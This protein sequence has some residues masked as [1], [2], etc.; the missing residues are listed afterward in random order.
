MPP[1][2]S[3]TSP[4][5]LFR[6]FVPPRPA[7]GAGASE[8][9]DNAEHSQDIVVVPGAGRVVVAENAAVVEAEAAGAPEEARGPT[10]WMPQRD[11]ATTKVAT[12]DAARRRPAPR[13]YQEPDGRG[14]VMH[15]HDKVV[16]GRIEGRNCTL[17][18]PNFAAGKYQTVTRT[19]LA[20]TKLLVATR[21][22]R[23]V[24]LLHICQYAN[25]PNI[26]KAFPF[27][28][29]TLPGMSW[30]QLVLRTEGIVLARCEAQRD[31]GPGT[32]FHCISYDAWRGILFLGGD[33]AT[34]LDGGRRSKG[35]R[36]LRARVC[37]DVRLREAARVRLPSQGVVPLR[38]P[39]QL[40]HPERLQ[41]AARQ[42]AQARQLW[43]S[44]PGA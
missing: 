21:P 8:G 34:R 15:R 23:D 7:I 11:W 17:E 42:Q 9:A 44:R 1:G 18:A 35:S 4:G 6:P 13:S 37:R 12:L 41:A 40:Q 25:L 36:G 14:N 22:P 31:D 19:Q 43:I 3:R 26:K 2:R 38:S 32:D 5:R 33:L 28:L 30:S 39:L 10:G 16:Q 24:S 20:A 29:V 27:T